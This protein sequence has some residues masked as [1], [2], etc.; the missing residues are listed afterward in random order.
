MASVTDEMLEGIRDR[1]GLRTIRQRM[2]ESNNPSQLETN[3]NNS[4]RGRNRK[5]VGRIGA[6]AFYLAFLAA[7]GG[8]PSPTQPTPTDQGPVRSNG[9][10]TGMLPAGTAEKTASL[11][12]RANASCKYATAAGVDYDAMQSAFSTTNGTQHSTLI[13]GLQDG[14]NYTLNARCINPSTGTKNTTD[15]PISFGVAQSAGVEFTEKIIDFNTRQIIPS[16]HLYVTIPGSQS[17]V[18]IPF[19]AG[20]LTVTKDLNLML[21]N[22]YT[23]KLVA[24]GYLDRDFTG[25]VTDTPE[26]IGI[27]VDLEGGRWEFPLNMKNAGFDQGQYA[28]WRLRRDGHSQRPVNILMIGIADKFM[29]H[30]SS[31]NLTRVGPFTMNTK[32]LNDIID[33]VTNDAP[34]WSGGLYPKEGGIPSYL[35]IQSRG[36]NIPDTAVRQEGWILVYPDDNLP[37]RFGIARGDSNTDNI[38]YAFMALG[39]RQD[40]VP[41]FTRAGFSTDLRECLGGVQRTFEGFDSNGKPL[42]ELKKYFDFAFARPTRHANPDSAIK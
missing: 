3:V 2:Y 26:G 12:T 39:F 10:P 25:H 38:T 23:M 32:A 8:N 16:G 28:Y 37:P 4:Y 27:K 31:G 42:P 36:D 21:N 5:T 24:P 11:E 17:P 15:F 40:G 22:S 1:A 9:Q 13:T 7:C 19:Q 6:A 33:A 20:T 14:N 34:I 18:D 29:Y 30:A 35:K 41:L